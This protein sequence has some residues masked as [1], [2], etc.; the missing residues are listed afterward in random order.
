[1]LNIIMLNVVMLSVFMLNVV[2][3]SQAF[4]AFKR[5]PGIQRKGPYHSTICDLP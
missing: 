1:M 2:D 5:F 3:P 4:M